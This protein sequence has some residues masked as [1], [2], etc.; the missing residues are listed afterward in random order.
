MTQQLAQE[1]R[2]SGVKAH[3]LHYTILGIVYSYAMPYY[4][5]TVM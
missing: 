1:L 3:V 4:A 5:N 2:P